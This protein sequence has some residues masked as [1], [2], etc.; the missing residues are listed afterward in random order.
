MCIRI[1]RQC[2]QCQYR[3]VW[4]GSIE[5][6]SMSISKRQQKDIMSCVISNWLDFEHGWPR[7][8]HLI[9]RQP[10]YHWD[11]IV[12]WI[13]WMDILLNLLLDICSSQNSSVSIGCVGIGI[14]VDIWTDR[15]KERAEFSIDRIKMSGFWTW[16]SSMNGLGQETQNNNCSGS[17]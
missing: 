1:L 6:L 2:N 9:T 16:H 14:R 4:R 10:I 15:I 5:H 12:E 8:T 7:Y 17:K 3:W 11:S 13:Y